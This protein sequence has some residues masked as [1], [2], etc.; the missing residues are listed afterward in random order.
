MLNVL[1]PSSMF[2]PSDL[3]DFIGRMMKPWREHQTLSAI[4]GNVSVGFVYIVIAARLSSC[5]DKCLH[6]GLFGT[7]ASAVGVIFLV[8]ARIRHVGLQVVREM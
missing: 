3:Q 5:Q 4:D 8:V 6:M 7:L 2:L 1:T